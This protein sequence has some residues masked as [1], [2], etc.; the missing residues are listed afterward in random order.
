MFEGLGLY[1][2]IG[3]CVLQSDLTNG[4]NIIDISSLTSGIYVIRLTGTDGT[5]QK[6]LIK[7]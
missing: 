2:I 4:T 5:T 7:N 1:I 6:K 3:K